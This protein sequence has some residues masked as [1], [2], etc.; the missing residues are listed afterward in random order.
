MASQIGC[1]GE[2]SGLNCNSLMLKSEIYCSEFHWKTLDEPTKQ[3][4]F[5]LSQCF[6]KKVGENF[7]AWNKSRANFFKRSK[8]KS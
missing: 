8:K 1:L 4:L 6:E 7:L 2:V 3:A 5:T